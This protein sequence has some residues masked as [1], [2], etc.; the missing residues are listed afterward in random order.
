MSV[1][2]DE[3]ALF[4]AGLADADEAARVSRALETDARAADALRAVVQSEE[5]EM[6][7]TKERNESSVLFS[8]EEMN[9]D[10]KPAQEQGGRTEDSALIDISALDAA[11]GD[12]AVG[13]SSPGDSSEVRVGMVPQGAAVIA[14]PRRKFGVLHGLA[15]GGPVVA[16][17]ALAFVFMNKPDA[18]VE[19]APAVQ[20][21]AGAA[22]PAKAAEPEPKPAA[23]A[24]AKADENEKEPAEGE[25]TADDEKAAEGEKAADSEK[26][27]DAKAVAAAK[28]PAAK[29]PSTRS[30]RKPARRAAATPT[31][32]PSAEDAPP[33]AAAPETPA[34]AA[35]AAPPPP[36]EKKKDEVDD[37]LS[38]LSGKP[39]APAR[40]AAKPA[41]DPGTPPVD[42]LLP[43]T[44]NKR[45]ILGV[46]RKNVGK[47]N[48]CKGKHPDNK[49]IVT[50]RISVAG[51]GK[52]TGASPVGG[53][54]N[55]T[56][57]GTCVANAVKT[58]RFPR[59]SGPPMS[60]NMPFSL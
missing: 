11:M 38:A 12:G 37:M 60:F 42:P 54:L 53:P 59:F 40:S 25:A 45:Q 47:V 24:A 20:A 30:A 9:L 46:V 15:I 7:D 8:L 39:A 34:P 50:I 55:G 6:S 4:A 28:K 31:K 56:P 33:P 19:P 51:S 18:T 3:V 10:M 26:P 1:D 44:L 29:K 14:R 16:L 27:A 41:A 23:A 43:K 13:A 22:A 52:V 21:A 17:G 32:E 58:Y 49:G 35:A 48:A 2:E 5:S 36:A 57:A